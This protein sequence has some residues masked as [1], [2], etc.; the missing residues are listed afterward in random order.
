M[1]KP[2]LITLGKLLNQVTGNTSTP[3]T[4]VSLTMDT[5]L[6]ELLAF[7]HG[8][9]HALYELVT[10]NQREMLV[11][12]KIRQL[13]LKCELGLDSLLTE[14][15]PALSLA[16]N[17]L[18]LHETLLRLLDYQS[19]HFEHYFD[20]NHGA[21]K[22]YV[23]A[24]FLAFNKEQLVLAAA[25]KKQKVAETLSGILLGV[26]VASDK[27][28]RFN[29]Q[30]LSYLKQLQTAL[31]RFCQHVCNEPFEAALLAY[32][33]YLNFNH[34]PFINYLKLMIQT[35]LAT[36]LGSRAQ[37][38]LWC[39]KEQ[40][41][42]GLATKNAF[43]YHQSQDSAKNQI[44]KY[45]T[46]GIVYHQRNAATA[47]DLQAPANH[48]P[49]DQYRVKLNISADALAYLLRLF[50]EAGII[51]AVPRSQLMLFVAK[52]FQTA[53]I[54]DELLSAN[55]LTTKYKQVVQRTALQINTMLK[56]MTK[57]IATNFDC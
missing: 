40:Y 2:Y 19:L 43:A 30:Q 48:L 56:R 38:Q 26:F 46:C 1:I 33:I 8:L 4:T 12:R 51:D 37:Y 5:F 27:T 49:I 29:Y 11:K 3:L 22:S 47:T 6:Q 25:L 7:E 21:P 18:A 31:I 36:L 16:D 39:A 17:V 55:S 14:S 9:Q 10:S 20:A 23:N 42:S 53:G 24:C 54:G 35:E 50:I 13:Q 32:L 34:V 44:L 41:F 57:T 45:I 15:E 52:H 28:E